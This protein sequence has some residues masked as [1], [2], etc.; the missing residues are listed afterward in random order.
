MPVALLVPA[1]VLA[2]VALATW[3]LDRRLRA[4]VD[5][6]ARHT[7]RLASLRA[8]VGVLTEQVDDTRRRHDGL[9]GPAHPGEPRQGLT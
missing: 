7:G 6:L 4:D 9:A 2:V 1:A 3:R 5:E 8:A